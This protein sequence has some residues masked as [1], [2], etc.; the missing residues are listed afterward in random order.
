M[1]AHQSGD[2]LASVKRTLTDAAAVVA[3]FIVDRNIWIIYIICFMKTRQ[4]VQLD[5]VPGLIPKRVPEEGLVRYPWNSES[6]HC[7]TLR[8]ES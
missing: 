2:A 3:A 6:C 4:A 8:W 1:P 7:R 5:I